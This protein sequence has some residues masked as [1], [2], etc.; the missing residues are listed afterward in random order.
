MLLLL[1]PGSLLRGT[2]PLPAVWG[3]SVR[4][5]RIGRVASWTAAPEVLFSES[6]SLRIRQENLLAGAAR[7]SPKL[8]GC[9]NKRQPANYF[10]FLG[11]FTPARVRSRRLAHGFGLTRLQTNLI[12][13]HQA[14]MIRD[15]VPD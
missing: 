11:T 9:R 4:A 15:S 5:S 12:K 3:P 7:W 2:T 6:E 13:A 10:V 1:L 14:A 8:A